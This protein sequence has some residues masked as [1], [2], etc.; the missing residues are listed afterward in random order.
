AAPQPVR[1]GHP[2]VLQRD[3]AV[4]NDLQRDLV[5]D[6][7]DAEARRRLVLDYESLDLV[8]GEVARPDD[9]KI[10]PRRVADPP[11]L[12]VEDPIVALALCRRCQA[13]GGARTD[14]RLG[15][16]EAADLLEARHWRQPLLLLL[17]R[18]VDV[19]GAHCQTVVD[20]D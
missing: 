12:A 6:L 19:D 14:Q 20:A 15:E 5:L 16:A 13:T 2:D 17:L 18:S 9:G 7:L 8:V 10:A 4:L 1:L 3:M 11:L